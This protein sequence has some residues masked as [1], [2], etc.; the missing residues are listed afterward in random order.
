MAHIQAC[1]NTIWAN[2][3]F[4]QFLHQKLITIPLEN[5]YFQTDEKANRPTTERKLFTYFQCS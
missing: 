2:T 3:Y 4:K 1:M 5:S